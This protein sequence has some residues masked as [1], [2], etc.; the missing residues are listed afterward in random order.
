[1]FSKLIFYTLREVVPPVA[2]FTVSILGLELLGTDFYQLVGIIVDRKI[3]WQVV[4]EMLYL[5]IPYWTFHTL[6]IALVL[7]LLTGLGRLERDLEYRAL[8]TSGMDPKKML[9]PIMMLS[10]LICFTNYYF[11]E[12]LVPKTLQKYNE[13]IS[14]YAP[15]QISESE[16]KE[17][18]IYSHADGTIVFIGKH[19]KTKSLAKKI[20]I[21]MED[22]QGKENLV[23]SRSAHINEDNFILQQ[24]IR[25][26]EVGDHYE[27]IPSQ[28]FDSIEGALSM[29]LI[30]SLKVPGQ[31]LERYTPDLQQDI[32]RA[33]EWGQSS[34]DTAHLLLNLHLKMSLP[35]SS[36]LLTLVVFP[37]SLWGGIS[38]GYSHV[39]LGLGLFGMFFGLL[40]VFKSLGYQNLINPVVAAWMPNL[41]FLFL[42]F[43]LLRRMP[44]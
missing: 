15:E 44:R 6:P 31:A 9:F 43:F 3:P 25:Y 22:D 5:R 2:L 42:G 7:G 8:I 29:D 24:G 21:L 20:L 38:R 10:T 39:F 16:I 34:S 26:P 40:N 11:G 4:L 32:K 13:L 36:I 33:S 14:R 1:M 27:S 19:D 17:N 18:L 30:N 12:K 28:N 23:L 35:L 37:L 41:I